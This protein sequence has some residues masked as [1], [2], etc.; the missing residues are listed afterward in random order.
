M[1]VGVG[2]SPAGAGLVFA[3]LEVGEGL[4]R[5]WGGVVKAC[6]VL[7]CACDGFVPGVEAACGK[8]FC[9]AEVCDAASLMCSSAHAGSLSSAVTEAKLTS[10]AAP[11]TVPLTL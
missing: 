4:F 7:G 1:G 9:A 8:A 11:T 6:V 2:S 5:A 3:F 10:S